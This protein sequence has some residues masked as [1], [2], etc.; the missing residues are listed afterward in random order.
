MQRSHDSEEKSR[1]LNL[2][3]EQIVIENGT[4]PKKNKKNS[5]FTKEVQVNLYTAT[6]RGKTK[7]GRKIQANTRE[8]KDYQNKT[9]SSSFAV[10]FS[11]VESAKISTEIYKRICNIWT[12]PPKLVNHFQSANSER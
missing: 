3:S 2:N 4:K 8:D 11:F 7:T 1:L 10:C 9:G 5:K 6:D 12:F